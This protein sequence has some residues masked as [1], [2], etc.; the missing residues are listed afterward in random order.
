[1]AMSYMMLLGDTT[2]F[3]LPLEKTLVYAMWY[4]TLFWLPVRL[5]CGLIDR[6]RI[7]TAYAGPIA[8]GDT[9]GYAI[10]LPIEPP[11]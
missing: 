7:I 3:S 8:V 2:I 6:H 1:M 10:G 4:A 5:I 11:M 9:A